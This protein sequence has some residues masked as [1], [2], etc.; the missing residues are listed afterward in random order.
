VGLGHHVVYRSFGVLEGHG[1]GGWLGWIG[2]SPFFFLTFFLS[3]LPWAIWIPRAM[4]DWWP[5]R[6]ADVFGWYL[7]VQAGVVFAV[8]T[9]VRTKLP[10]YTLPAFPCLALWLARGEQLGWVRP[11]H[12]PRYAAMMAVLIIGATL[13]LS[14]LLRPFSIAHQL[15]EKSRPDLKPG[16][17][18][19][20]VQ[21]TEPSLV[22]EFRGVITNQ[23]DT[24]DIGDAV[25]Y[26]RQTNSFMMILPTALYQTNAVLWPTNLI[27]EQVRGLNFTKGT[28]TGV[29]ALIH[30]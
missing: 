18:I 10:H 13:T 19:A 28:L 25:A 7:L 15:F 3:F 8:F 11:L 23:L 30:P 1:V 26:L 22:W 24:L 2:E 9:V 4:R 16:M 5:T 14:L 27:V 20:A 17:A 12:V 21:Y 6:R 29:T